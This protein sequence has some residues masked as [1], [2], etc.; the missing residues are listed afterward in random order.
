[1]PQGKR[2]AVERIALDGFR[3]MSSHEVCWRKNPPP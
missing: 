2:R 3:M 1:M